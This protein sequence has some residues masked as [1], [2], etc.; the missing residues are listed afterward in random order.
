MRKRQCGFVHN[1]VL[2]LAFLLVL[3]LLA[4]GAWAM[5]SSLFSGDFVYTWFMLWMAV[6]AIAWWSVRQQPLVLRVPA[7][8]W[9]LLA[10]AMPLL[11][12]SWWSGSKLVTAVEAAVAGVMAVYLGRLWSAHLK[13]RIASGPPWYLDQ[14]T[15]LVMDLGRWVFACGA[16]WFLVG[17]LP[18]L[19][20][21]LLPLDRI[22]GAATAWGFAALAWYC[23][24]FRPSRLRLLKV[25]LGLWVFA[26][27][28]A[29][30]LLLQKQITGPLEVGSIGQ[31]AYA[32]YAP[33]VCGLFAEIVVMGKRNVSP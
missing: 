26:V 32:A 31:I 23:Y 2:D 15:D 24:R 7:G 3:V 10:A 33:V 17:L 6:A 18:L 22:A 29:A 19:L 30:L 13:P 8:S 14:R 25:P 28:A 4:I 5:L 9:V 27:S 11:P 20:V 16:G 1:R 12:L 21:I